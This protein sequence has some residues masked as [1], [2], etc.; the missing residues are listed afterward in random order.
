MI[1][2]ENYYSL[3]NGALTQSKI[4]DYIICPNMCYRKNISGELEKEEKQSWN[5]GSCIDNILTEEDKIANYVVLE[6]PDDVPEDKRATYWKTK[7]GKEYKQSI[8][9]SGSKVISQSDY[10]LIINCADAVD[11]TT[12]WKQIKKEFT[13]QEIIEIKED[14]GKYFN[15]R[16]GKL[17]AYRIKDGV[18]DL[19]DVK[20]TQALPINL[21]TGRVDKKK[22]L[23]SAISYGYYIQMLYY[24]D[25]L[26]AKYPEIKTFRFLHCA[27]EKQEPYN[28]NIFI[29]PNNEVEKYEEIL[30]S[31]IDRIKADTEF[32]K[33]DVSL[34][35][36][37]L[38]VFDNK[39]DDTF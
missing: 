18:C 37:E 33:R 22:Y 25:L 28:V 14:L 5:V 12:A 24:R 30:Y 13:F 3:N 23:Y 9:D 26:K 8:I 32:K 4:K 15:C 20:S 16:L 2:D 34:E 19:L 10:E 17:D 39:E 38:L 31:T 6:V 7:V 29:I 11:K 27:I 21:L 35:T 36:A 1:N